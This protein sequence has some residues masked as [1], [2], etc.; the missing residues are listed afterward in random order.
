MKGERAVGLIR[1]SGSRQA[2]EDRFSLG[3]QRKAIE[4]FCQ[5]EGIDLVRTFEE[6]G[7][8]AYTADITRIPG[9]NEAVR[10]IEAGQAEVLVFHES[11][12][13]ARSERLTGEVADR[14]E[15]AGGR[16]VNAS[17]GGLDYQTPE[18]RM[19][20]G[21]E[22]L[23]NAYVSRKTSQHAKK[24]K[25]EQ[26]EAGLQVG[27]IPFGYTAATTVDADGNTIRTRAKPAVVVPEEATH[28]VKAFEDY[29]LGK[30]A[31]EIAR[32]WNALGLKP[33]SVRGVD[34]FQHQTVRSMLE[35]PFYC[36]YVVHLGEKRRGAHEHIIDE[37][38]FARAQKPKRRFPKRKHAPPLAKGIAS[39]AGCGHAIYPIHVRRSAK[40]HDIFHHYYREPSRD[41]NR[42]CPDSANLWR[43]DQVDEQ[44]EAVVRSLVFD[45]DWIKFVE[46][47]ARKVPNDSASKRRDIEAAYK[48]AQREFIAGRLDQSSW[49][50]MAD[51]FQRELALLPEKPSA[52]LE[53]LGRLTCF[54]ELWDSASAETR[55][56]ACK[57]V[58]E[59]VVLNMGAK[60]LSLKPW[61]EFEPL[62]STRLVYVTSTQPGQGSSN[63]NRDSRLYSPAELGVAV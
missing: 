53:Q 37:E 50:E 31:P 16:I 27:Q 12:R 2:S 26:F 18:G 42:D 35:N 33:R 30:T 54:G 28:I 52:L 61:P 4:E 59:S 62:L 19:M 8:S 1:V 40:K 48:R 13:L 25:R 14:V 22:A 55:N 58:F 51:E 44:I 32:E 34:R 29:I 36:G 57:L 46:S 49:D 6:P 56:E 41:F 5:R 39:C 7:T 11:S 24:G 10:M 43:V 38:T 23:L 60:T 9:L 47:E 63:V 17:M 3:A 21:N 15:A 45:Q 20:L